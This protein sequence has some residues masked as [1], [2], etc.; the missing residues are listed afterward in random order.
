MGVSIEN[1]VE[2]RAAFERQ[3][4]HWHGVVKNLAEAFSCPLS[5]VETALSTA[6][7]ELEQGARIKEFIPVLAIK[8]VRDQ[9]KPYQHRPLDTSSAL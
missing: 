2:E 5:E 6:A 3:Q 7:H 9:L 1:Q 4:A 8:Q